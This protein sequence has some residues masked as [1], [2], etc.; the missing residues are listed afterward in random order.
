MRFYL[1][2]A[3]IVIA[4]G[5]WA[6]QPP[7][8]FP[9]HQPVTIAEGASLLQISRE[10]GEAGV[11]RWP[12]ILRLLVQVSGGEGRVQAGDYWFESKLNVWTIARRLVN[13][14]FVQNPVKVTIPAGSSPE[15]IAKI[16]QTKFPKFDPEKLKTL[17][18]ANP[19]ENMPDTYF[20]ASETSAD[21]LIEIFRRN[22]QRQAASLQAEALLSGRNWSDILVMSSLVEEEAN[23]AETRQTIAG[24]LWKRLDAKMSLQVDVAR[25]TYKEV[26]LP[27]QAI[28]NPSLGAISATIHPLGSPY[29]YYLADKKGE[30]H[31]AI[32]FADHVANRKKYLR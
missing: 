23:D 3:G 4:L 1:L 11:V 16:L 12:L 9:I 7:A 25:A 14:Q 6:V 32:T 24:I 17:L 22:F 21:K 2:A 26:G 19:A 13:G 31:Y 15:Q 30:T 27:A 20:L 10:L 28:V 18:A 8:S 29:W 5:I